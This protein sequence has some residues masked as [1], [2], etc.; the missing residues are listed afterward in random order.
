MTR[1]RILRASAVGAMAAIALF[2]LVT[3]RAATQVHITVYSDSCQNGSTTTITL[4][5]L[6]DELETKF[7]GPSNNGCGADGRVGSLVV[8]P[9]GAKDGSFAFKVVTGV[10]KSADECKAPDYKGCI[11]ARRGLA[12]LPHEDLQVRVDMRRAC[13]DRA[14]DPTETCVNGGCLPATLDP[15]ACISSPCD[16]TTLKGTPDLPDAGTVAIEGGTVF[17]A[18][19][20]SMLMTYTLLVDRYEVSVARFRK[21]VDAGATPPCDGGGC[22]LDPGGPFATEMQWDRNWKDLPEFQTPIWTGGDAGCVNAA[23]GAVY[24]TFDKGD[25]NLPITCINF[26]HAAAFCASEGKRLPTFMEFQLLVAGRD[27][28]REYP[29]G[30]ALPTCDLAIID[31]AGDGVGCGFPVHV[32]ALEAGATPEGI[33]HLAG[34]V[35]EHTWDIYDFDSGTPKSNLIANF[36]GP[37]PPCGGQFDEQCTGGRGSSFRSDSTDILITYRRNPPTEAYDVTGIRC[38]KTKLP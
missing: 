33:F 29:W 16:E 3:C 22:S 36:L 38:V 25:E 26:Y 12:F 34:N 24:S 31:I 9:S 37:H 20:A 7:A 27:G 21:W 5:Q 1:R 17:F 30:N 19:D 14:C 2:V 15:S 35:F 8:Q 4:G 23:S 18:P 11:V 13:I 10:G 6:G 28:L 32:D